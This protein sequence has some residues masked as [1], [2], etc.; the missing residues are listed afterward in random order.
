MN[1]EYRK[2]GDYYL[3]NIRLP[4]GI[5]NFRLGKYSG[6]R[7]QYLKEHRRGEY[8]I[9]LTE[10]RLQKHLNEVEKLSQKMYKKLINEFKIKENI[11]EELKEKDQMEWVKRMNNISNCADEIVLKE[12]VYNDKI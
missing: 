7:L 10:N 11:T 5:K 3:P 4:K 9:L 2:V 6:L 8:T 1:I 12:Y